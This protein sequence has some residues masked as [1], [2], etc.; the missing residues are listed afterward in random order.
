[1]DRRLIKLHDILQDAHMNYTPMK[2]A[3][4]GSFFKRI[5]KKAVAAVKKIFPQFKALYQ[6]VA[7][8]WRSSYGRPGTTPLYEGELHFLDSNY[9]GPG[10]L[11]ELRQARGDKPVSSI[12][13]CSMAHDAAYDR[14]GKSVMTAEEKARAVHQA[15]L[16]ALACY[17]EHKNDPGLLP[18][19]YDAAYTG[20]KGKY[21]AEQLFS[22]FKNKPSVLYGGINISNPG[23]LTKLGYKLAHSNK[24]RQDALY[25]A[26]SLYGEAAVSK[27]LYALYAFNA[28]KPKM[29]KKIKSDIE[30][31]EQFA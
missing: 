5:G 6:K 31:V 7:N 15:D 8:V 25:D 14:I 26:V 10:T 30:Y 4:I 2:G 11:Y 24:Q 17:D 20:I 22:M 23:S 28:R 16:D 3:G 1:M 19:E 27:K 29:A 18:Y 9:T 13:N 12:D 21:D